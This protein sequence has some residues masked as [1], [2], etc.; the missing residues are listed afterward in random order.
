MPRFAKTLFF[1][2]IGATPALA[3][4]L[5]YTGTAQT[6][7]V[8]ATGEYQI[9]AYGAQGGGSQF[10]TSGGNGAEIGGNFNLTAGEMLNI[11]VGGTGGAGPFNGGGGGGT[12][13]VGPGN[14]NPLVVAGGGGGSTPNQ[15]GGAGQ[16]TNNGSGGG[17]GGTFN[18]NGAGGGGGFAGDGGNGIQDPTLLPITTA[19]LGGKGFAVLTGGAG[20][21]FFPDGSGGFGGG[22]GA[23]TD[24]G[25]GGGG[26]SGGNGGI[27]TD[28]IGIGGG[29]FDAGL[30]QILISGVRA[31]NGL[32]IITPFLSGSPEPASLALVGAALVGVYLFGRKRFAASNKSM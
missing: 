6:Y 4:T 30:D 20:D 25:G 7:T 32:V 18:E 13:V 2:L 23:G 5:S 10:G 27:G 31:G 14:T 29:S 3:D 8:A 12:F 9:I 15:S 11:Y 24:A 21:T 1:L 22:G 17:L 19:G 28:D 26:Y 16:T